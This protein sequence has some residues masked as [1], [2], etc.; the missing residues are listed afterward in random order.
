MLVCYLSGA[1]PYVSFSFVCFES[2][3]Y[4]FEAAEPNHYRSHE[5]EA[6]KISREVLS[7]ADAFD[8]ALS[9]VAG[10]LGTT[11]PVPE[12]AYEVAFSMDSV[13][14]TDGPKQGRMRA[15]EAVCYVA[16]AVIQHRSPF[17]DV[18]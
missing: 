18:G 4:L 12:A 6:S 2:T 11:L 5:L 16:L 15:A 8:L 3:F 10:C 9:G 13:R 7:D 1:V 17:M 14:T